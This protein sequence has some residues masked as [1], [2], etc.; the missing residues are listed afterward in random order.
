MIVDDTGDFIY[1]ANGSIKTLKSTR[2][3]LFRQGSAKITRGLDTIN[4]HF[5]NRFILQQYNYFTTI[6]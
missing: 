1:N 5:S 6:L 2:E 3:M 4:I